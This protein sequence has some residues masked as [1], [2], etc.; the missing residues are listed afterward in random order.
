M[1]LTVITH[2]LDNCIALSE[3]NKVTVKVLSGTLNHENR[4]FYSNLAVEE[5]ADVVFD[6]AFIAASG[7]DETGAYLLDQ[8][9]AQIVGTAVKRARKVILVAEHQKFINKS[10]YRIC[11]LDKISMF[12][13][14]K[15]PTKEQ[16]AMFSP[17]TEIKVAK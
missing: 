14:D 6:A 11:P 9:D 17:Y 10:Y 8:G 13:T 15:Q 3:H 4:Y 12:I 7:I 1:P 16:L 2:S 5:L